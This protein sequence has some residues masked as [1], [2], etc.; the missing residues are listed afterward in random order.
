MPS[1]WPGAKF[2]VTMDTLCI[3]IALQMLYGGLIFVINLSSKQEENVIAENRNANEK[4]EME[5]KLKREKGDER[6]G[7]NVVK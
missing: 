5:Q 3:I 7:E 6:L 4:I 2:G 1:L